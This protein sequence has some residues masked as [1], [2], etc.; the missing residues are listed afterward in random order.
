MKWSAVLLLALAALGIVPDA[1]AQSQQQAQTTPPAR[2]LPESRL[3][4][5][6]S[7]APLVKRVAPAVVNVYSRKVVRERSPFADDPFFRRFFGDIP[8]GERQ[9]NSLGSGVILR[10]DG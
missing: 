9:Q 8:G 1:S 5:Q 6:Q 4:I 2:V 10:R 3:A 7:F